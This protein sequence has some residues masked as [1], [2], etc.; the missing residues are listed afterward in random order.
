MHESAKRDQHARQE[1]QMGADM[2]K[3]TKMKVSAIFMSLCVAIGMIP[4]DVYAAPSTGSAKTYSLNLNKE[5][6]LAGIG[7]PAGDTLWDGSR[8]SY[9]SYLGKSLIWRVLDAQA[10]E[11]TAGKTMLLQTD[12]SLGNLSFDKDGTVNQDQ[13]G[14]SSWKNSDL[15]KYLNG[16]GTD[17]FLKEFTDQEKKQIYSYN[18]SAG[19][20]T[21]SG[22]NEFDNPGLDEKVFL[23]SAQEAM[24]ADY[25][26]GKD[27]ARVMKGTDGTAVNWWLRSSK[28]NDSA[29]ETAGLIDKDG[30]LVPQKVNAASGAD[31]P[32]A[33]VAPAV[34]LD[35][36]KILFTTPAGSSKPDA[37]SK[38]T[39]ITGKQT[40]KLTIQ[41]GES[42]LSPSLGDGSAVYEKGGVI[43]INHG[44]ASLLPDAVQVSALLTDTAGQPVYY[45]RINSSTSAVS[46]QITIPADM[47]AGNYKLFVFAEDVNGNGS[48]DY[49]GALGNAMDVTVS[50][51]MTPVITALPAASG[52]TYGQTLA[53]STF[54]G[55]EAKAGSQII[56]GSFTWKNPAAVPSVSDGNVTQYDIIFTPQDVSKYNPVTG[57]VTVGVAKAQNAPNTPSSAVSVAYSAA[58][59]AQVPLPSGWSWRTEDAQKDLTAGG[60]VQATAVYQDSANYQNYTVLVTI[61]RQGCTHSGGTASCT[62]QAVCTVCG[63]AYG[64]VDPA[65]HGATEV[66]GAKAAA[67]AE[68]GYS[69]DT[70]C[71]E[72]G[73]VVT[74]GQSIPAIGHSYTEKVTKE[75]TADQEGIKTFTCSRCNHQYT[76]AIA[77]LPPHSHYYNSSKTLK[78][79]GCVQQGEVQY[80]CACGD[81]YIITTPALGHDY[82]S[83]ITAKATTEKAGVKTYT[84]SRCGHQ[85][86]EAIPKLNGGSSGSGSTDS[87][88]SG[89]SGTG[90]GNAITDRKPFVKGNSSISGWNDINK[91]IVKAAAGETLS[92]DM[93]DSLILPKKTLETIKDKDVTLLLDIGNDMKW[94]ING[95]NV[96][97]QS[98]SDLNLKVTKN[99]NSIPSD[100]VTKTAGDMS[101]MQLS[102]VHEGEFGATAVLQV[103]V[104]SGKAGHYANLFYY[105]NTSGEMEYISSSQMDGKGVAELSMTHASEYLLV[106][107]TAVFDGTV[108]EPSEPVVPDQPTQ[109]STPE[110]VPDETQSPDT[111]DG[112]I[113]LTVILIAG[114]VIVGVGLLV[115]VLLRIRKKKTEYEDEGQF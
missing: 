97:A 91:S 44:K 89:G 30:K 62:K 59:V 24:L 29:K 3:K 88:G 51:K 36:S 4:Q 96:T 64:A 6:V 25:G 46:S 40:W 57:K 77:K 86:T 34:Y 10:D 83:A 47:A 8:I 79:V 37:F 12:K 45:G 56:P 95:K 80:I 103:L 92:I 76:A 108:T 107:D 39:E 33:G 27:G 17:Q 42:G 78:Y 100:T 55:G 84:C 15:A 94:S 115:I 68:N 110:T 21:I 109:P 28:S 26:Y 63:Q 66:R 16:S 72:C 81:S 85:Y 99:S 71:K 48:T 65:K 49:A 11:I 19:S 90:G 74:G 87:T 54:S 22:G 32:E 114:L 111:E 20:A 60:S 7:S 93:N 13:T 38:V 67:C 18:K 113:S 102:L 104:D 52:I 31:V 23:L 41:T 112:G 9:G 105:N 50:D 73:K 82:K 1:G 35:L 14:L 61:T 43:Q 69:G 2:R 98:L 106:I 53:D 75:P 70:Y 101:T 5:G 58:K